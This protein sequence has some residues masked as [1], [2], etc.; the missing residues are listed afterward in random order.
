M[1]LVLGLN[2]SRGLPTV[3]REGPS[4]ARAHRPAA[5]RDS[6]APILSQSG[7]RSPRV[8]RSGSRRVNLHP[9]FLPKRF[10]PFFTSCILICKLGTLSLLI[11][12][13]VTCSLKTDKDFPGVC[14]WSPGLKG[15][16]ASGKAESSQERVSLSLPSLSSSSAYC[17]GWGWGNGY[18]FLT[19]SPSRPQLQWQNEFS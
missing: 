13:L 11:V 6:A 17:W 2:T 8:H 1:P 16:C 9:S 7:A 10:T 14:R 12:L 3:P 5:R 19:S 18:S 15:G 4:R